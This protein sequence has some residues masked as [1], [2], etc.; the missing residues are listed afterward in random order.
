[1]KKILIVG[2]GMAGLSA[3]VYAQKNGYE[4]VILEKN[5]EIGG[6]CTTW[7]RQD[8]M[9]DGCIH[10]L[11]GTLDG[12]PLNDVWREVGAYDDTV[13]ISP[14]YFYEFKD[15]QNSIKIYRDLNKF[16]EQLLVYSEGDEAEIE[17]FIS[18]VHRC[19][20]M[21][22][23]IEKPM[24][25]MSLGDTL[26][27]MKRMGK[28]G[29]L[30]LKLI[31]VSCGEYARKFHSKTLQNFMCSLLP[32]DLSLMQLVVT[33]ATFIS[34]NGDFPDCSSLE[35]AY[36]I[37][38]KYLSLGGKMRTGCEVERVLTE[39]G[40][41]V[42]VELS[43]G[44]RLFADYCILTADAYENYKR[45]LEDKYPDKMFEKFYKNAEKHPVVANC[46][47]GFSADESV[48]KDLPHMSLCEVVP[49]E[50][51]GKTLHHMGFKTYHHLKNENGKTV[52][53]AFVLQKDND[54]AYWSNLYQN[55]RT[56]YNRAK[57]E[58]ARVV[59]NR[60][61]GMFPSL[62]ESLQLIDA[63]TPMTYRRYLNAHN[64]A[65]MG[66]MLTPGGKMKLHPGR[67]K[68][69]K[70]CYVAGQW[71]EAPGG[72]PTALT[73]GKFALQRICKDDKKKFIGVGGIRK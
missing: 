19:E 10:W 39:K 60:L 47:F 1:M 38:R 18:W 20:D 45:I 15:G 51:A 36:K 46:Y 40:K 69:L 59:E 6:E 22:Y 43:G 27:Y 70:N 64:G 30:A 68:K 5:K 32:A 66:F 62:T 4:S 25:M 37:Y 48:C 50:A 2:G 42:G 61:I 65:Y 16:R 3:G 54:F 29:M 73:S 17:T 55:D 12:T 14:D 44:E 41:A 7:K 72:L 35:F 26:S 24:D 57:E 71:V 23:M 31:D 33:F 28:T 13:M 63:A 8:C 49:F 56:A 67:I 52:I 34:G 58:L 53:A 11:T 9:I 21:Q